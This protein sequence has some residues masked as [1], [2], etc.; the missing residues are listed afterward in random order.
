MDVRL[1]HQ[2]LTL[3]LHQVTDGS[4][5]SSDTY[6]RTLAGFVRTGGAAATLAK[7]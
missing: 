2:V 6:E 7:S 1:T 5:L 4:I 3:L